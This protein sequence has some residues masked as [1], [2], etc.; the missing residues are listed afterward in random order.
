MSKTGD[1]NFDDLAQRF[2]RRV[3]GGL[4]G[5][6]RLSVLWRDLQPVIRRLS[7]TTEKP[8]RVLD[9]GGGLGQLAIRLAVLGHEVTLNDLSP[10][11]LAQARELAREQGVE[12]KIEWVEGPYQALS[13]RQ[14]PPYDIVLCH[15][16][17]E[18]LEAPETAIATLHSLLKPGGYLSLCFYNPAAKTY[19]NLIRGN[20]NWLRESEGYRSDHGS[21]TPNHPSSIEQ[22]RHWLQQVNLIVHSETGLRVFHDYVVEKRGGHQLPE[23]VLEMELEYSTQEP[24]KWLGRYLHVVA[25]RE[26]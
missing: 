25:K 17:L 10:V 20:F 22:V 1:R 26:A 14:S 19:R 5:E 18:W 21:L 4:K 16:L 23:Q 8:L 3:Y 11:M 13:E 6:I 15:A 24:Y 9:A 2:A 7:A 12:E